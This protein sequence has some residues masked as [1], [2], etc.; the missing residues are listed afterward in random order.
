LLMTIWIMKSRCRDAVEGHRAC[1]NLLVRGV[2]R[3]LASRSCMS[4]VI[5]AGHVVVARLYK[6]RGHFRARVIITT[7]TIA[8]TRIIRALYSPLFQL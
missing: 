6:S 2:V 8:S 7:R 3:I 1:V 5:V 4:V